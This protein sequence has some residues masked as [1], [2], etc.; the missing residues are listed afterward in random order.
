MGH[1]RRLVITVFG[2]GKH[3]NATGRFIVFFSI[4][5]ARDGGKIRCETS[6]RIP[7]LFSPFSISIY[8]SVYLSCFLFF[9]LDL[10]L[11]SVPFKTELF[12]I[13]F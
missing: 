13:I 5:L 2:H 4:S 10:I 7:L 9:S 8:L 12:P 11:S 1:E 6:A 3:V